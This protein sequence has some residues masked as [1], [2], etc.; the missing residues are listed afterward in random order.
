MNALFTLSLSL[1]LFAFLGWG[2]R[3]LPGERWQ[4][5]A[6]V[7]LYKKKNGLWRS[8][9][10]T[11]YGFFIAT[12]QLLALILALCLLGSIH[13]SLL[14]TGFA[15]GML[16]IF[17]I[18][19]ARVM[20]IIVEKKH[21]TFTIGGASFVGIILA[22][23]I[24]LL[25][26]FLLGHFDNTLY[27]PVLPV[28]AAL[29]IAYTMGEGLGRLACLSYG[30]CYGKPV[31]EAAPLMKK[32]FSKMNTIFHGENKKAAYES[33][34]CGVPLIPIQA[35][36]AVIYCLATV[37]GTYCYLN[38]YFSA[39]LL[40]TIVTSQLWRILSETMRA[41]FRGFGKISAYQKMGLIG[42]IYMTLLVITI[43]KVAGAT[44][45]IMEGLD[46]LWNPF[47]ILSLQLLWVIFFLFFGKSSITTST[48]EFGLIKKNL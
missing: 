3:H 23:W 41:D 26:Q 22:P 17:C 13:V 16:M 43:P 30:C 36:T 32:I 42:V 24:I 34:L 27:L 33:N 39:A 47:I 12:S 48:L 21:H 46:I 10:F 20:A 9:N 37:L 19:A 35:I 4:F 44:P 40:I 2:F 25:S 38:G 31:D 7:P 28:L 11:Y 14:G 8:V 18:P 29:S 45:S 6:A 15:I 5:L 1:V